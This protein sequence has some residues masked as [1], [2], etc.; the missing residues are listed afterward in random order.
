MKRIFVCVISAALTCFA[1]AGCGN[2]RVDNA[3]LVSPSPVVSP[4]LSPTVS[5]IIDDNVII[6]DDAIIDGDNALDG[7]TAIS[8]SPSA[9]IK[10]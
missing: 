5:P 1:F 6:G 10:P 8:P 4:N 7:D 3:D 9:T 2:D